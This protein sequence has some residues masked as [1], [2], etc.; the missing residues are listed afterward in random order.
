MNGL[1]QNLITELRLKKSH[2][3]NG[4][5]LI[6]LLVVVIII[7]V[8]AAVSLPNLLG[9]IG[10]SRETEAKTNLGSMARAQQAY[11]FEQQTFANS[12]NQLSLVGNFGSKYYQFPDPTVANA[13]IVKHQAIASLNDAIDYRIRNY[14]I[15]VYYNKGLFNISLCQGADINM[16][17]D[18]PNTF[19]V[20]GV[21]TNNGT[22]LQ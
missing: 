3:P 19:T 13:T 11:H 2:N 10:K 4:F 7:G 20:N 17:V 21:C 9:Q 18:V 5:T 12:L 8:L 14:T 1:S 16:D 22:R 6:E 15:G